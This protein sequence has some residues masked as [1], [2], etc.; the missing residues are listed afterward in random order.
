MFYNR[1]TNKYRGIKVNVFDQ[2]SRGLEERYRRLYMGKDCS[3]KIERNIKELQIAFAGVILLLCIAVAVG[4]LRDD[5]V[6]GVKTNRNG[7]IMTVKRPEKDSSAVSF[8]TEVHIHT[9]ENTI[10]RQMHITIDPIGK[11]EEN[12]AVGQ[13]SEKTETEKIDEEL[14][15]QIA[16]LNVDTD[17]KSI[18]L[19]RKLQSGETLLWK[20][21]TKS[22]APL[23][24]TGTIILM[25]FF[26][27]NRFYAIKKEEEK[28]EE[29][30]VRELPEFI[31][32]LVLLLNAGVVI[33]TAFIKIME[34]HRKMNAQASYFYGQ[35]EQISRTIREANGT[36]HQEFRSFAKR[37]GVKELMRIANIVGD[38]ISKGSDLAEKLKKENELLWFARKQQSK[39]KG[40]LAETKLTL[41]LMILLLVLIMVTIAPAL[42]EI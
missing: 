28:A 26:Y 31:N 40:R 1:K 22:N 9:G 42:M 13:R 16:K 41:P 23:Y 21:D 7:E 38:N 11:N 34:D 17:Q 25:M 20:M 12:Q 24:F 5:T 36:L 33:N 39:E 10:V 2:F 32:K 30:I 35:M 8:N 18:K 6:D 27:K 19:P 4:I 3:E 15:K 37:S 29:S 14:Q